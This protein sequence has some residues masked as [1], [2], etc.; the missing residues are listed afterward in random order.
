M[1]DPGSVR[2][3][4]R[5]GRAGEWIPDS[6]QDQ[7]DVGSTAPDFHANRIPDPGSRIP[8]PGSR[9]EAAYDRPKSDPPVLPVEPLLKELPVLPEPVLPEP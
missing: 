6:I 9:P 4:I 2:S 7:G 8:D 3:G 1:R 5:F